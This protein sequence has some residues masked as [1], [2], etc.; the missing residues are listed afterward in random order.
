M[1]RAQGFDSA[2]S[3]FF[4]VHQDSPH[5]DGN[6]AGFGYVTRGIEIVDAICAETSVEDGNGSVLAE[7]QPIIETI[8][9]IRG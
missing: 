3:Q 5:L 8:R 1:A 2:S 7:N 4:I 9:I 6:Y